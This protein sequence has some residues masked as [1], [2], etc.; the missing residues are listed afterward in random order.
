M[1]MICFTVTLIV[2]NFL[3][4]E[5]KDRRDTDF[6]G[7]PQTILQVYKHTQLLI[8]VLIYCFWL[9]VFKILSQIKQLVISKFTLFKL[10][11]I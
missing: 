1:E 2:I 6:I 11:L 8:F 3:K 10:Y 7:G 9:I 5:V 4:L